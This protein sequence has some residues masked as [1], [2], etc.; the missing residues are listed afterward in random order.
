MRK[1]FGKQLFVEGILIL[2]ISLIS[3]LE[4]IRLVFYKDPNIFY[5][6]VGPGLYILLLAIFLVVVSAV[7]FII[8]YNKAPDT[9][10][11][12]VV[13]KETRMRLIS[14]VINCAIYIFLISKFG[15]LVASLIFFFFQFK[16]QGVRSWLFNLILTFAIT[17]TCYIVFVKYCSL[18]FPRGILDSYLDKIGL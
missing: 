16:I 4:G 9:R 13:S 2:F 5:D 6:P 14:T 8:S 10:K 3:I 11:D 1:I 17:T 18:I 15:Y 12:V 7:Q